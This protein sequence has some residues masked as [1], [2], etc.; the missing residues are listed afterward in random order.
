MVSNW[1][2]M[3]K[4]PEKYVCIDPKD[5]FKNIFKNENLR[6]KYKDLLEYLV[7][8]YWTLDK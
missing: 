3:L 6:E 1:K 4:H 7:A 5:L 2:A 8:R